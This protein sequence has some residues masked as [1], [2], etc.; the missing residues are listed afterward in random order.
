MLFNTAR[1]RDFMPALEIEGGQ[2]EVVEQLKVLGVQITSD[3]KWN[4]NTQF[5]TNRGYK[6]LWILR[7][8]KKCGANQS[9]LVD[10]YCKHV[11]SILEYAAVVWHAG[12]TQINTVDIER[13]QKAALSI[14]LGKNY[15]SYN[16]ALE[17][18]KLKT[19]SERRDV[20]CMKFARKA[21]K[22]EK[23]STWFVPDSNTQNTRRKVNQTKEACTRTSRFQKSALPYLTS[24]LN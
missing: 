10:I 16:H 14:I 8:L 5:I 4:E 1:T 9:E 18:L 7:R 3:L 13:V 11:R 24:L 15:L 20:L 21:F 6:K 19:F 23:Y 17:V 12:L 22:S 2:I